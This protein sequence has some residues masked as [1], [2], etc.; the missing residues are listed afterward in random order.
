MLRHENASMSPARHPVRALVLA[1][2]RELA[3]QVAAEVRSHFGDVVLEAVIPRS[4][5]VSEAPGYG[6]TVIT[7]DA[8]SRGAVRYVE[9]AQQFAA[10][11]ADVHSEEAGS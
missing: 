4:V 9:A 11:H 5:R 2:T 8:G 10:R 7:Y 6:Q 3:D 1:P